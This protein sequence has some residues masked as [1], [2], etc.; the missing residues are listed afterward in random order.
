MPVDPNARRGIGL[1]NV[2]TD[3]EVDQLLANAQAGIP[4]AG[5]SDLNPLAY[6]TPATATSGGEPIA[7]IVPAIVGGIPVMVNGRRYLIALLPE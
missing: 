2:Y 3:L 6:Q 4:I 7:D 1:S 5:F